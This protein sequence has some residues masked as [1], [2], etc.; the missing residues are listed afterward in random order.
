MGRPDLTAERFVPNP[1]SGD[2]HIGDPFGE[3]GGRL[4]KTGDLAR[5]AADGAIEFLGRIDHQIQLRGFRIE[6]GEIEAILGRAPGVRECAVLARERRSGDLH[7]AAYLVATATTPEELVA[8]LK[9]KLPEHMIPSSFELLDALPL[10]PSG[11]VDRLAL[12]RRALAEREPTAPFA[13]P[14]PPPARF[15]QGIMRRS[16]S[17]ISKSCNR[18]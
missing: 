18:P 12:A 1:L 9:E 16:T 2:R 5:Y 8:F 11:K 6:L 14:D 15:R 13:A 10:N 17:R 3:P 4:Y 7:L